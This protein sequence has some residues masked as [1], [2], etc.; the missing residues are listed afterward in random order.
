MILVR[1]QI[2]WISD[3]NF[4]PLCLHPVKELYTFTEVL[5]QMNHLMTV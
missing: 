5:E 4:F 2:L 1:N 3:T